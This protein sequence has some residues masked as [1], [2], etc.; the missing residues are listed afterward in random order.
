M[1]ATTQSRGSSF[2]VPLLRRPAGI[3]SGTPEYLRASWALFLAGFSTFSLLYC[4]QPLLPT[5]AGHFHIGAATSALALSLTTGAL[6]LAI[7]A[8]GVFSQR[9]SRRNLMFASMVIAA[10]M[11]LAAAAAPEWSQLLTARLLEGLALG[12]VPAV[13]MAYLAEEMHPSHLGKAMGLY[14]GGTAF[15]GMAGRVGMGLVTEFASWRGAMGILGAIDLAAAIGFLVLLPPSRNFV[16]RRGFD[17]SHHRRIWAGHLRDTRLVRLF[18][19]GFIL[20]SVFVA[21]FN[22]A[23]FRLAA[24]PYHLGEAEISAIFLVYAFGICASSAAGGLADRFGRKGPLGVGLAVMAAG[25]ATTLCAA[26]PL[27]IAGITLV[28]IGFF[29]AH[30][31]A[32]SWI[33]RLA[34]PEKSQAAALYLL[35]YYLGSSTIGAAAGWFWEGAAWGGVAALTGALALLGLGLALSMPETADHV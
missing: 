31:V 6:A 3:V 27:I 4:V 35:F 23:G 33:G 11:N 22:F 30:S 9:V 2:E 32:S 20:T 1:S 24:S 15:G 12:G 26:L 16:I 19:I 10:V 18:A 7:A 13:A 5:F 8:A 34:G 29:I 17:L 21:L 25:V 14:V 28:T